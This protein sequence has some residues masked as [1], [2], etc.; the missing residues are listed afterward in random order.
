ML[1]SFQHKLFFCC[2][3]SCVLVVNEFGLVFLCIF[4]FVASCA[5]SPAVGSVLLISVSLRLPGPV[6][7]RAGHASCSWK[8]SHD[9]LGTF[10]QQVKTLNHSITHSHTHSLSDARTHSLTI[11]L[12]THAFSYALR[13][14]VNQR[15]L[16]LPCHTI[17]N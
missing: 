12:I 8:S 6:R 10:K 9:F 15:L 1:S 13:T 14:S 16:L 2:V 3:V 5:P 4:V 7:P 17:H 11:S